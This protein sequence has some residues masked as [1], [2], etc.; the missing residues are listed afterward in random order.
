MCGSVSLL[1]RNAVSS[2][3]GPC[4]T[5]DCAP[6]LT[7][8]CSVDEEVSKRWEGRFAWSVKALKVREVGVS[9][10]ETSGREWK[11]AREGVPAW[12][13]AYSKPVLEHVPV[14]LKKVALDSNCTV[15]T[16]APEKRE[17]EAATEL[18]LPKG[19][20]A[21]APPPLNPPPTCSRYQFLSFSLRSSLACP[22]AV[23]LSFSSTGCSSA[24][25]C[26]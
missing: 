23:V 26:S 10:V 22:L 4:S 11:A 5:T 24:T 20:A 7:L 25:A 17:E 16:D 15:G 2:V 9:V 19:D 21:S 12:S 3:Y 8:A 6:C 18:E 13:T 14:R 1:A